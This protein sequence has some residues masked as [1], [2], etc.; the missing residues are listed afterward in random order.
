MA[1]KPAKTVG[2]ITGM[3]EKLT[4]SMILDKIGE[5]NSEFQGCCINAGLNKR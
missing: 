3:V 5:L 1:K 4:D 2:P